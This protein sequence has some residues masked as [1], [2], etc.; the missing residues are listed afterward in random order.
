M[1]SFTDPLTDRA[2]KHLDHLPLSYSCRWLQNDAIGR[3]GSF[4]CTIKNHNASLFL[5]LNIVCDRRRQF[6]SFL[7]LF[8]PPTHTHPHARAHAHTPHLPTAPGSHFSALALPAEEKGIKAKSLTEQ[9]QFNI[10]GR[11]EAVLLQVF[12]DGFAP[13]QSRPLLCAQSTSHGQRTQ[14]D[15]V[16]VP[17]ST[18]ESAII[19]RMNETS[20]AN[21][22][23]FLRWF[24][25]PLFSAQ[26]SIP[27]RSLCFFLGSRVEAPLKH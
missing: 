21:P 10:F 7:S 26:A 6:L 25:A 1:S 12:L 2:L 9:Q 17:G 16:S 14:L 19:R 20:I 23:S 27:L 22:F 4:K 15:R 5:L 24:I 8:P 18:E 13:I 11:G 3:K